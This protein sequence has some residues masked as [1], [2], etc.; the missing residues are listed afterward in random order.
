[1]TE[2]LTVAEVDDPG[3]ESTTGTFDAVSVAVPPGPIV[4]AE[5]GTCTVQ[6]SPEGA[7]PPLKSWSCDPEPGS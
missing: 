1:M 2:K 4:S 5:F 7:T 3:G 6:K